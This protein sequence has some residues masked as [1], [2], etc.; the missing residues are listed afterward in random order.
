WSWTMW[1]YFAVTVWVSTSLANQPHNRFPC[2]PSSK[3]NAYDAFLSK[4]VRSDAPTTLDQN[5]WQAFIRQI[6]TCQRPVQSFLP[7]SDKQ[8]VDRVCSSSGGKTFSENLCISDQEFTF[9]TVHV[10]NNCVVRQV[11]PE[12]KYIILGCDELQGQ[13]RPVHFEANKNN[14]GPDPES[15]DCTNP[16]DSNHAETAHGLPTLALLLAAL[17][18]SI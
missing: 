8:R 10:D 13:C 9:T 12:T 2:M 3:P 6:G 17:T 16:G 1:F 5:Q 18:I 11:V 14:T 4:H 15:P 7:Y